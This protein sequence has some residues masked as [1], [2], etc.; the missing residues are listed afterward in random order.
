MR[1]LVV[2]RGIPG[3]GKSYWLE[4]YGLTQYTISPDSIRLLF[5]APIMSSD[6]KMGIAQ[7]INKK[8]WD[9]VFQVLEERMD[10]GEFIVIDAT[11]KTSGDFQKYI[12]LANQ[13][14]YDIACVDFSSL[15]LEKCLE[16]NKKRP[17]YKQVPD[18]VI[19]KHYQ[20][21]TTASVPKSVFKIDPFN[22]VDGQLAKFYNFKIESLD[23][24]KKL[25][26]IGDIQGCFEPLK[27]YFKYGFNSDEFYVF[28]GDFLDRGIQNGEVLEWVIENVM[29]L[30]NVMF[31]MGN[32]ERHLV[33]FAS[34]MPPRDAEFEFNTL[35][36]LLEKNIKKDQVAKLV[37]KMEDCA[38]LEYYGRNI[39]VSH[40]GLGTIPKNP[41]LITSKQMWNGV[42]AYGYPIDQLFSEQNPNWL[43]IHG[44]RN[45][46]NL[47][48]IATIN[49]CNLEGKIEFGGHL[50]I[51]TLEHVNGEHIS[52]IKITPI[53]IKNDVYN[54]S[55]VPRTDLS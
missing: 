12:K 26:F 22:D 11:H 37:R 39:F 4:Q 17:E 9:F 44:H 35:P 51:V 41:S 27:E 34:D 5:N 53:E 32:H 38:I 52:G 47:P 15:P 10:R 43:Q 50:R 29:N 55:L 3:S 18:E 30:Q 28:T 8:V 13:Y 45:T 46:K 16:Q 31:I 1:K 54:K 20:S 36:Q 25:H 19:H 7:N 42:G 40:A 49:S 24:Y 23:E 48:I 6:G 2:T 21:I 14:L 33:R